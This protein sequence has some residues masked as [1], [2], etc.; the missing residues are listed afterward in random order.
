MEE[1]PAHLL[2]IIIY[3]SHKKLKKLKDHNEGELNYIFLNYLPVFFAHIK[4]L[5]AFF[6]F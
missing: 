2:A 6:L 4:P 1:M 5:H 3:D